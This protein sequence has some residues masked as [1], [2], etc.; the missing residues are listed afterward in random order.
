MPTAVAE[1]ILKKRLVIRLLLAA[2]ILVAAP[3]RAQECKSRLQEFVNKTGYSI[4]VVAPCKVWVVQNALAIPLG[5]DAT[6]QLMIAQEGD[7][8]IIGVAVE[9]KARL[10]LTPEFLLRLAQKNDSLEYVKAGIDSDGDL[11]LRSE[12]YVPGLTIEAFN[13]TLKKVVEASSDVYQMLK[14]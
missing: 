13:F 9:S 12:L 6:G 1:V 4:K 5:A 7:T 11:F 2:S 8:G 3:V 14:K 10:K